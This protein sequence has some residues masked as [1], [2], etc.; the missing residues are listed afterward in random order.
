MILTQNPDHVVLT[1][2]RPAL[3]NAMDL[4]AWTAL[5]EAIEA[6]PANPSNRAVVIRGD[7]RSFSA[8]NDIDAMRELDGPDAAVAYFVDGMLP[9]FAA[10]A[11]APLPVIAV[12][13]GAALGGGLEIVLVSDLVI[14]GPGATFGLPETRIGAWPTVFLGAAPSSA[15]RRLT[16]R[17]A[18]TGEVIGPAEA[19]QHGL[20]SHAVD[21]ADTVDAALA[22][23]LAG[24]GATGPD[25]TART[26]RWLNR[27][28]LG[29]GMADAAAALSELSRETLQGSEFG[30]RMAAFL[31]ARAERAARR[32]AV[33]V[34]AAAR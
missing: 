18:L 24:I 2:D 22:R 29:T 6:A 32:A 33:G 5:R 19:L 9:T 27:E 14:A 31:A 25:A 1:L 4:D 17:L 34:D 28:L 11:A 7:A 10:M 23:V 3:R 21:R 13:E 8:G 26:K 15:T 12:V 30:E 20:V 16:A